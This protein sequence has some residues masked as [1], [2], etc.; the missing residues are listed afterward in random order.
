MAR[1]VDTAPTDLP[2]IG[3]RAHIHP[4]LVPDLGA[5]HDFVSAP[6]TPPAT[7]DTFIET[8]TGQA[9]LDAHDNTAHVR[10]IRSGGPQAHHHAHHQHAIDVSG[11]GLP[12]IERLTT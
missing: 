1:T 10:A 8:W 12:G 11:S 9:A 5:T 2:R 6:R 3:E 7:C 4:V